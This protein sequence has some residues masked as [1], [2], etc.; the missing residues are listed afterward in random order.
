LKKRGISQIEIHKRLEAQA[1][2]VERESIA[3]S[4]I[5]NDASEEKLYSQVESIWNKLKILNSNK[6]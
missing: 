1:T 4:V 6:P 3:D 5:S 2:D